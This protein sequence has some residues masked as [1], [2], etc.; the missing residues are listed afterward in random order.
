[1]NTHIIQN[2]SPLV[3]NGHEITVKAEMMSLT[4]MWKASGS[5]DLKRPSR[6]LEQDATI[7]FVEVVAASHNVGQSDIIKGKRG[8]NGGTHAHW[9]IALAYAKYLSPEFHMWCNQVVRERMEGKS[10][11]VADLPPE[12]AEYIRRTDGISRM[13]AHKVTEMEKVITLI[14]STVQPGQPVIIRQGKT[15]GQILKMA[16]YDG[17]KGLSV[18]FGNRLSVFGCRAPDNA[19]AEM[20]LTKARLFDPDKAEMYLDNGGRIALEQKI[21]ERKGQRNLRLVGGRA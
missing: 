20:G 18:W 2:S 5:D 10:V 1:M 16:G 13:L 9:Q 14:A 3:Y 19:C 6:W 11:S 15:A 7:Q 4:D 12:I 21:A 17:I 8:K